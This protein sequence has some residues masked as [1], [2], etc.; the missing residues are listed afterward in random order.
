MTELEI[1]PQSFWQ[2]V[3]EF[4]DGQFYACHDTLEALWIEAQE[5]QKTFY[6]GILQ[7]AVA[8]YHLGNRNW[9][10]T[11]ILLGE[12]TR[13]LSPY[14]AS[15]G[16][17]DVQALLDS[18]VALLETLQVVGAEGIEPWVQWMQ[19]LQESSAL[20]P[21]EPFPKLLRLVD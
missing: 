11:V 8:C 19:E 10:G 21:P 12:G 4:N 15:Y 5:P 6:Q 3:G 1:L 20:S 17:V 13:R 2:G 14:G 16:G 18:S 7:I 9:R